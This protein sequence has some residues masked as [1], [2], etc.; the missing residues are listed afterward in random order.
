MKVNE[1]SCTKLQELYNVKKVL[2]LH[3]TSEQYDV[4]K[5]KSCKKRLTKG[6][7]W[8]VK[9]RYEDIKDVV[10]VFRAIIAPGGKGEK[11]ALLVLRFQIFFY[12]LPPNSISH[13]PTFSCGR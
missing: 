8:I 1:F 2:E 7:A 4:K 13:Y 6:G 9:A 12:F 5:E 11:A 10:V 3:T